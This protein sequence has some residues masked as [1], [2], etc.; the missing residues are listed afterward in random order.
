VRFSYQATDESGERIYQG[1]LEAR[2]LR[3]ARIKLREMGLYPLSLAPER[4]GRRRRPGV[5]DLVLFAEQFAS[6]VGAGVPLTQALTTL[7]LES[8]HPTLRFAAREVRAR[9]EAGES[10]SEA[11]SHY[12]EAFPPMM[13]RLI[14][15]GELGGFLEATLRRIAQ[16]LDKSYELEQKVKTALMYPAFV[17]LVVL[18]AVVVLLVVV[19]PVFARIYAMVGEELPLFTRALIGSATFLRQNGLYL[20]A[21]LA[22]AVYAFRAY[23]KTPAGAFVVDRWMLRLPV[24]GVILQKSGLARFGRTFAALYAS[25]VHVLAGLEA[26]RD[27]AGNAYM[28]AALEEVIEDVTKGQSL[29]QALAKHPDVFVPLFVRMVSV[30]EESGNLET[31][32]EQAANHLERE[33]EYATKRLSAMIEPVL[34]VVVGAMLLGMALALYLPL[35]ELPAKLIRR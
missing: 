15:A 16:Y 9:I 1:Y 29:S 21:G 8:P 24:L 30:G 18:A 27:L 26:A 17:I 6:L 28:R 5:G 10:L 4:G 22:G 11:M 2:D 14:A 12:P 34:T 19:V 25:G 23:Y 31:M 32:V 13:V 20:L 3:E 7:S 35:F 33:V